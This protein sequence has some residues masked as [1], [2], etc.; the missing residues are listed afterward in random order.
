MFNDKIA[1]EYLEEIKKHEKDYEKDYKNCLKKRVEYGATYKN[2]PVPTLYQGFFYPENVENDF[3]KIIEI[4]MGIERK[5]TNE[6]LTNK[7]Y[8]KLFDFDETLEKMILAEVDTKTSLAVARVDVMYSTM[9]EF[10]FCEVNTDGSSAMLED[11]SLGKI[12]EES[13][14][15]KKLSEKYKLESID[16]IKSLVENLLEIY[17]EVD[18]KKPNV[19][20]VDIIENENI[21]F[22]KIK[23]EFE[24]NGIKTVIADVRDLKRKDGKLYYKD[25]PIDL[26]YRRLVTSDLI[27]HKKECKEFI[28]SYLN[29]E[30]VCLGSLRTSIFYT[31]DIFRILRLDESQK[32]LTKEENQF[33]NEHIPFTEEFVYKRD[34]EK[35]LANKDKYIFKPKQSY[36]SH[37]VIVGKEKTKEELD[38]ELRDIKEEYIYQEYYKVEP[39]KFLVMDDKGSRLEDFSQ[40]IGLFVYKDKFIKPYLR[41]GQKA[42][43]SSARDYYTIPSFKIKR[44]DK[45]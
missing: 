20:I 26:V 9:N 30:F 40:V 10:K 43:I 3:K 34:I 35:I 11:W 36:A 21:E 33:I 12:Y 37:G 28:D 2:E 8:R 5:V 4:F 25:F 18:D 1:E 41:I 19:A 44:I 45:K 32:I 24:N 13:L 38:K 6:Y 27:S 22:K 31:K 16:L 39:M 7:D 17:K 15:Y 23:E 29:N 42:L 14:A